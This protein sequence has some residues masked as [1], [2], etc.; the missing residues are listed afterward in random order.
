MVNLQH[1]SEGNDKTACFSFDLPSKQSCPGKTKLCSS[2]CYAFLLE[3]IYPDVAK[4]YERNFALSQANDFVG[5]MIENIPQGCE[6]RIH[7]SG[8]F[9]SE[10]YID[11]WIEI[12]KARKDVIFYGYTRSWRTSLWSKIQALNAF[13]NVNINLSLDDETGKPDVEN[14]DK[15]RW[16]FLTE[17]DNVPNFLRAKDIVFRAKHNGKPGNH[18]WK[19]NRAIKNGLDPDVVA[20]LLHKLGGGTVCPFE[21]GRD[22]PDSFSCSKCS[23]CIVKPSYASAT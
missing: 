6:F 22:M 21:R 7:V 8:D 19:R 2:K 13:S 18:K 4:K 5:Y 1:I 15:Y 11:K 14:A 12:V 3:K 10:E 9:Y 23:L 20:P 17:D 16:C